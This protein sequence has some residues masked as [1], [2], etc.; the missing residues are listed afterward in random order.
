MARRPGR[1][2]ASAGPDTGRGTAQDILDAAA[3]LFCTVGYTSTSTYAI[4]ERAGVRQASIYHHFAG[5][6]AILLELLLGTVR[7]SLANVDALAGG[8]APIPA[9]LWALCHADVTLLCAGRDNLGALYLLP[10]VADDRF[11]EF[12]RLHADLRTG[13]ERLVA[14][15]PGVAPEEAPDLAALVLGLVESV[16]LLRRGEPALRA[17]DVAPRVADAVQRILGLPHERIAE[18]RAQG[19]ALGAGLPA[20]G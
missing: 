17:Q 3:A 20:S 2:R 5:K 10:E 13:Y 8:D 6:H 4:A 15:F 11:A 14:G 7:P 12:R 1:P 9:R 19:L 18:V 16:I